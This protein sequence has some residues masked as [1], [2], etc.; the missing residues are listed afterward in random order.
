MYKSFLK[1]AGGKS[2]LLPHILPE[3][4]QDGIL[5]EPFAGSAVVSL[6]A[7]NKKKVVADYNL[8][9]INLYKTLIKEKDDFIK[10]CEE[11]FKNKNTES[12]YYQCRKLFNETEDTILKS[13]LFVYLNR[14]CFNGLCRY[15]RSGLFNVPY[16]KYKSPMLPSEA[17]KTFYQQMKNVKFLHKSFEK[18]MAK[19]Q[20]GDTLYCDPPYVPLSESSSFTAYAQSGFTMEQQEL[21]AE[22]TLKS[23]AK[24]IV[25]N[26]DLKVVRDMYRGC[27]FIKIDVQRNISCKGDKR[28]IAKEI[29]IIKD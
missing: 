5:I 25:S 16:G 15:N 17:M 27:R 22:L 29:L 21:L 12:G 26:H 6:N 20:P 28:D 4:E 8:D 13:A 10:Q 11:I 23:A 3:I 7:T 1:W 2:K 24:V 14:H 9:L 19:A 18:I